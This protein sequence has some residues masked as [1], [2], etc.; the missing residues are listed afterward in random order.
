MNKII[1]V[2]CDWAINE[3]KIIGLIS[4]CTKLFYQKVPTYFIRQHHSA[5]PLVEENS[6]LYNVDHHHDLFYNKDMVKN[7]EKGIL[8]EANWVLGLLLHKK[9]NG[10]VW[11]KNFTSNADDKLIEYYLRKIKYFKTTNT[12]KD[13]EDEIFNKLIICE[14]AFYHPSSSFVFEILKKIC[15]NINPEYV[16]VK[17]DNELG[18]IFLPNSGAIK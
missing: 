9:L 11:V 14:S 5:F 6:F 16:D 3:E 15:E 17:K 12:I 18:H 2:D 10:Y 13:I 8:T 1:T 4:L 7:A